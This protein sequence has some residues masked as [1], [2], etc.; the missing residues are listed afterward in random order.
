MKTI[1]LFEE[2]INEKQLKQLNHLL[3]EIDASYM[4]SRLNDIYKV[5]KVLVVCKDEAEA[6]KY[7]DILND[8]DNIETISIAEDIVNDMVM[9]SVL[10]SCELSKKRAV[11]AT[12]TIARFLDKLEEDE[13]NKDIM[14]QL[15][16]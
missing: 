8:N 11:K 14:K 12:Y 16:G 5:F 2:F 6:K 7:N 13:G 9:S 3:I 10:M 4:G 15:R 1:K